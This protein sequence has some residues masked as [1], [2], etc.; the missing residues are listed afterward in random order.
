MAAG[1]QRRTRGHRDL[2]PINRA[3][4]RV[5]GTPSQR[6]GIVARADQIRRSGILARAFSPGVWLPCVADAALRALADRRR[7]TAGVGLGDHGRRA[8]SV[9]G[10]AARLPQGHVPRFRIMQLYV[11]PGGKL[12]GAGLAHRGEGRWVVAGLALGSRGSRVLV[13][14]VVAGWVGQDG[15]REPGAGTAAP[16]RAGG[17]ADRLLRQVPPTRRRSRITALTC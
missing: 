7:L 13:F 8:A 14:A 2:P 6:S 11:S 12:G 10:A 17:Y 3:Q 5:I 4:N 15:G 1:R 9:P 16:G